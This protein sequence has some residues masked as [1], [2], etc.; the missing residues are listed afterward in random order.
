MND[1]SCPR[2][3]KYSTEGLFFGAKICYTN[4]R[5]SFDPKLNQT[6][7]SY[8]YAYK[9]KY[10]A[11]KHMFDKLNAKLDTKK[12]YISN[13]SENYDLIVSAKYVNLLKE[14]R[15]LCTIKLAKDF[16]KSIF[17]S[18][19]GGEVSKGSVISDIEEDTLE[20]LAKKYG[21]KYKILDNSGKETQRKKTV[22]T[23]FKLAE[24]VLKE[25]NFKG[26]SINKDKE[27][28]KEFVSGEENWLQ[29]IWYDAWKGCD[30]KARDE[31]LY[32]KFTDNYNLIDS[33]LKN[34][35]KT[36]GLIG[37]IKSDGDW[38]DGRICYVED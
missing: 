23:C 33:E 16:N 4:D 13:L 22:L 32:K 25:F 5:S 35:L 12:D 2:I 7:K 15:K 26:F 28:I 27:N 20:N 19:Y 31:D 6:I 24:E 8:V 14:K 3:G 18:I 11:V 30:G 29:L 36:N 10:L 9:S 38:D 21:V 1:N 17:S 34:R 37:R